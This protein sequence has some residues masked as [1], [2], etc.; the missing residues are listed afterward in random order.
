MAAAFLPR[1]GLFDLIDH[2]IRRFPVTALL[3]PRQCGKSSLA[4]LFADKPENRFDIENPLDLVRLEPDPLGVLASREGVVVLD[5]VQLWPELTNYLRV[6]VDN[7]GCR[8]RFLITGSASPD[9]IRRTS[10]SLAG[11]ARLIE[12]S[13]FDLSETG[14]VKWEQLWLRGGFPLSFLAESDEACREWWD[15]FLKTYLFRDVQQT[16]AS[17][18]RPVVDDVRSLPRTNMES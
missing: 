2:S 4:R 8:A 12:M 1:K 13:G 3:G 7:P 16:G 18:A 15:S 5:E 9:L 11:R 14:P 6:I 17:Q 10:D